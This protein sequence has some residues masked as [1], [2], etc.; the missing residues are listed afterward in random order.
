M[1]PKTALR[2]GEAGESEKE[3]A[4]EAMRK[5]KEMKDT[6]FPSSHHPGQVHY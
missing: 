6:H 1:T 3:T 5:R 4:R 2:R